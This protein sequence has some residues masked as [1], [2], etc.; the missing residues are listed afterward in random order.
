MSKD[1]L[2]VFERRSGWSH[3]TGLA[4][5]V[6]PVFCLTNDQ[7]GRGTIAPQQA[8]DNVCVLTR[9]LIDLVGRATPTTTATTTTA[10]PFRFF[11]LQQSATDTAEAGS[12]SDDVL[13]YI[14][15]ALILTHGM[16]HD[17]DIKKV[18]TGGAGDA[19]ELLEELDALLVPRIGKGQSCECAYKELMRRVT[20]WIYTGSGHSPP[21]GYVIDVLTRL[22]HEERGGR[23][24]APP[25]HHLFD[26][27]VPTD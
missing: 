2:G 14:S 17:P 20:T 27:S 13:F 5:K 18:A 25:V 12:L 15:N 10:T 23:R 22:V 21:P 11:P 4:N 24:V 6:A 26:R 9:T 7:G 1:V 16:R 19:I 8:I 3:G